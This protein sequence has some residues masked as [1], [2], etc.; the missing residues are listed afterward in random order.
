MRAST[1]VLARRLVS[2]RGPRLGALRRTTPLSDHWGADRGTPIDRYFIERF[3]DGH[4]SEIRGHVLEVKEARY[5]ELFGTGVTQSDV[6]DIDAANPAATI[7]ADLTDADDVPSDTFDCFV[8]T[9]TLQFIYD[10]EAAVR[11]SHR[12]LRPGGVVLV[13]VPAVSR[14]DRHAGVDGDFWRFT[15][16]SCRRLFG[17]VFGDSRI[18]AYAYGNV[19]AA[20]GFLTGLAREELTESELDVADE[21][22]PVLVGVRAVKAPRTEREVR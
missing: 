17:T 12:F 11:E 22:F 9:Q 16:A 1:R 21:L 6:I 18:E 5:T 20:I 7:I 10:V 2:R 4:R 19:L 8:L 13:T 15:T 3:L 14:V